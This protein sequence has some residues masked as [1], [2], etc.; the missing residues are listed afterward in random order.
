MDREGDRDVWRVWYDNI[1]FNSINTN[2][3]GERPIRPNFRMGKVAMESP[4]LNDFIEVLIQTFQ[5]ASSTD[6]DALTT[7][8][9]NLEE[10]LWMVGTR[11]NLIVAPMES[12]KLTTSRMLVLSPMKH[13]SDMVRV[14]SINQ[15]ENHD[16]KREKRGE[17]KMDKDESMALAREEESRVLK[18]E[19]EKR[20]AG[21]IP[22]PRFGIRQLA[23]PPRIELPWPQV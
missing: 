21:E 13:L 4:D 11:F 6:L 1:S 2:S 17:L 20:A 19:A 10:S 15:M 18:L 16:R 12:A 8:R 23:P 7:F 22:L 14:K 5:A 3:T 9:A